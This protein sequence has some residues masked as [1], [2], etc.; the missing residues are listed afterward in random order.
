MALA[1][2]L[3]RVQSHLQDVLNTPT[4]QLDDRLLE[5][6]DNQ[7]SGPSAWSLHHPRL[8]AVVWCGTDSAHRIP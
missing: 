2:T 3:E 6:L 1:A 5:H 4:T 7:V 8:L